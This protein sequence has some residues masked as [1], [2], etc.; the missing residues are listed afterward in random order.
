M[1]LDAEDSEGF[2]YAHPPAGVQAVPLPGDSKLDENDRPV[3]QG[4]G[5]NTLATA[6]STRDLDD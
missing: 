6:E 4:T 5:S 2:G 1:Q 3:G